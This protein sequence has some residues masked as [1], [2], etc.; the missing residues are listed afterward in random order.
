MESWLGVYVGLYVGL[1]DGE[2]CKRRR[3]KFD[4]MALFCFVAKTKTNNRAKMILFIF[5]D[6][7]C[8]GGALG[9]FSGDFVSFFSFLFFF[10]LLFVLLV[11]RCR[12]FSTG[13][14]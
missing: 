12:Y 9:V 13:D 8:E 3:V 10:S 6:D 7:W 5:C 11:D 4:R 2:F 14:Q 1:V